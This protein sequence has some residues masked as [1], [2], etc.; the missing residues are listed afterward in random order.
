MQRG[1]L[2]CSDLSELEK[3]CF[4]KFKG[5]RHRERLV[6]ELAVRRDQVHLHHDLHKRAQ[7]Q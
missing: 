3:V 4:G 6:D 5:F 2:I 7:R 1:A